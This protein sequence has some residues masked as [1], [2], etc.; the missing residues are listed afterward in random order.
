MHCSVLRV[1]AMWCREF[2]PVA[3]GVQCAAV[4]RGVLQCVALCY[5]VLKF[6]AVCCF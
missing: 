3:Y 1:V 5:G 4:R 6:V 2:Q